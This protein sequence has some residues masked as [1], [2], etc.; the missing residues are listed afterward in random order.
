MQSKFQIVLILII[1]SS[2]ISCEKENFYDASDIKLEFSQDTIMFDTIFTTIGTSTKY[3]TVKNPYSKTVKVSSIYLAGGNNSPYRINIDGFSGTKLDNYEIKGKDSLYIFIEVTIDPN[4]SDLPLV[5]NDSIIFAYKNN[6]QDVNLV[7]WGQDVNL[8]N[9][10]ENGII[11]GT[12]YW[13]NNKPYL[14]YNSMLVDTN[15]TL[16][17]APG[18][19]L[20]FHK[21]SRLYVLGTIIADGTFEEPIIFQGDRP[22]EDYNDIPGQWDGIW[23][24]AGSNNNFF[25]FT[26]IKNAIIG[27]QVDTLANELKPTLQLS[28][29]KILNMT[30]VGLYAQ[31]STIEAHN[32]VIGNCGQFAVALTI[33]GSYSFY[34]CTIANYWG[35]STRT[36]PSV[37]LNNYYIDVD[38]NI[39]TRPLNKAIFGNCIIYGN[40]ESELFL[41]KVETENF[42][43]L[44]DHTL[45]KV[46]KDFSTADNNY[47]KNIIV[48][49]DP[50]FQSPYDNNYE[51]DTLSVAKDYGSLEYGNLFPLDINL[52]NRINDNGPD[53]GAFER[54]ETQ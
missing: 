51:L 37:L 27:I 47:F 8:I 28:N 18:T 53:L 25:D 5:V 1:I 21:N 24:M 38:N 52:N 12:Q 42:N 22:E 23:L 32:N 44:F 36:T 10:E 16:T 29:S 41:D 46:D 14:I 20:H 39:Q 54:I 2:I 13:T 45:I 19:K 43:F 11:Q 3:L 26:E 6:T 33:G 40:K 49:N 9:G 7:S 17:I 30:A 15:S 4:N 50:K 48:N 31:G 35:Y 34:H